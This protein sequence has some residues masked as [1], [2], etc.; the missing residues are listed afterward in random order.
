M[1]A[2]S[3]SQPDRLIVADRDNEPVQVFGFEKHFLRGECNDDGQV[4]VADGSGL[5]PAV[6]SQ[7]GKE[8][9][10]ATVIDPSCLAGEL[11]KTEAGDP[12]LYRSIQAFALK[13][14]ISLCKKVL[15]NCSAT[16]FVF[17]EPCRRWCEGA[18]E[19]LSPSP[20]SVVK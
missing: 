9:Q 19:R 5:A 15:V 20:L 7:L 8:A 17:N 2:P 13:H 4:D 1:G 6:F 12:Q 14:C 3:R 18:S 11:Y 10:G 16:E